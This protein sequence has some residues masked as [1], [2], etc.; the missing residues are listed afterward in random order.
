S[1]TVP[2]RLPA[3]DAP[4]TMNAA[5]AAGTRLKEPDIARSFCRI[6]ATCAPSAPLS[7][8]MAMATLSL[9]LIVMVGASAP[10]SNAEKVKKQDAKRKNARRNFMAGGDCGN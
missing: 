8:P 4:P 2:A 5:L 9:L 7:V 1:V 6:F 10:R 3:L